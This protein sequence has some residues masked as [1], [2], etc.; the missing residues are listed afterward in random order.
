MV[1]TE[2]TLDVRPKPVSSMTSFSWIITVPKA[3]VAA[4]PDKD[5]LASA[6]VVG[7]P[8]VLVATNPVG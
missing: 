6:S 8:T 7:V 3:L 1:E 2:P 4:M 5:T